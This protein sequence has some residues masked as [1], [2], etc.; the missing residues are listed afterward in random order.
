MLTKEILEALQKP[1]PASEIK[2]KIQAKTKKDPNK[3]IIV[4]YIDARNTMERLDEVLAGDW[5]DAYRDVVLGNKTGTECMLTV[6]GVTRADIGDPESDGM[7]NSLKSSYSDAFKRAAVKF[8]VG[9]FLY[10]LPKMFAELNGNY[11]KDSE[12]VRLRNV[13]D[14]HLANIAVGKIF[15]LP[16]DKED[17]KAPER[18]WSIELMETVIS[19]GIGATNHEEAQQILQYCVMPENVTVKGLQSWLKHY[20]GAGKDSILECADVAN[21]A[22]IKA[23][24]GAK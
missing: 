9:R 5:S 24:K 8:G 13:I 6:A 11:I 2:L 7:D 16:D 1:F 23:K 17:E 22:Y 19:A 12:L 3:G 4:A 15:N 20:A 14:N 18:V 10:S 21:Q